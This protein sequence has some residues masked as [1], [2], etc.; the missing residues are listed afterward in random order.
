MYTAVAIKS[1]YWVE[2]AKAMR[3]YLTNALAD[4]KNLSS[5]DIA[6]LTQQLKDYKKQIADWE[7]TPRDSGNSCTGKADPEAETS[8]S[9]TISQDADGKFI[10]I[11]Q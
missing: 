5:E 2:K 8:P 10:C 6:R 9:V 7:N 4:P 3:D 1:E 11:C